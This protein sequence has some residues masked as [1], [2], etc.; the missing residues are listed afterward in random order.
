LSKTAETVVMTGIDEALYS[1]HYHEK[2]GFYDLT[3]PNTNKY[4][5]LSRFVESQAYVALGN[6][7]NDFM[8]LDH[9]QTAIFMGDK[10]VYPHADGYAAV[11]DVLL[12]LKQLHQQQ[13]EE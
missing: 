2:E 11:D 12:V 7:Q 8:M 5:T 13:K 9:A 10:A 4:H 1:L 3:P 6:D